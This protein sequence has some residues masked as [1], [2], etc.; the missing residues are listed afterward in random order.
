VSVKRRLCEWLEHLWTIVVEI[1][2]EWQARACAQLAAALAL[3]GVLACF[4]ISLVG[5]YASVQLRAGRTVDISR[6]A[7]R[8]GGQAD[9]TVLAQLL[10]GA[11]SRH[12]TWLALAAGIVLFIAAVA[13][14][15][16]L[17]QDGMNR[18]W[19]VRRGNASKHS[20][21]SEV[22][23]HAPQFLG[24]LLLSFALVVLLFAGAAIHALV[25]RTHR[26]GL[27][28]GIAYQAGD[29]IISVGVLTL[30][31]LFMFAYIAPVRSPWKRVWLAAF[32]S[33]VLYERGQFGLAIY[34]GQMDPRSPYADIGALIALILWILYSAEVVY[35]GAVFTKVLNRRAKSSFQ[36]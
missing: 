8:A 7:G 14:S 6:Q 19:D 13:I 11:Q 3:Y 20:S 18:I 28:L 10:Q 36:Q 5:L 4:A 29:F 12:D 21:A 32:V 15:A 17:L 25:N 1:Y 26:I 2:R 9:A 23:R 33:A 24:M 35:G 34:I 16:L 31:F 27:G 22:A 30:V